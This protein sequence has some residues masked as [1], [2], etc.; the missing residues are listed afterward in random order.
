MPLGGY[1]GATACMSMTSNMLM[2]MDGNLS[3][4]PQKDVIATY[5]CFKLVLQSYLA[6]I[7]ANYWRDRTHRGPP[8]QNCG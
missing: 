5:I 8:N 4:N 6:D 7:Q 3:R 1:R 2:L